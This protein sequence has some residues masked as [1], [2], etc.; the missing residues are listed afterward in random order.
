MKHEFRSVHLH[1]SSLIRLN[2][3][4]QI[5][6]EYLQEGYKL[7]VRQL[8]YQMVGR[9]LIENDQKEYRK[10]SNLVVQGRMGGLIDFEAIED[11]VRIPRLPYSCEDPADAI[12][13]TI[14]TY[15]IDR[16]R[17]QEWYTE[18]WSEKDALSGLLYDVTRKYHVNLV[19]NRGYSSCSAMYEA[20]RR[21]ANAIA[22]N[23]QRGQ[24]IYLG[25]HD[26]SGK[27][28][29]RDIEDRL[30]EFGVGRFIDVIPVALTMEQIKEYTPPPYFA[31]IK[32]PRA[33]E[34]IEQYGDVA[35]EVD[36][37]TPQVLKKV[38]EDAITER[39]D[40][41]LYRERLDQEQE[42][43]KELEFTQEKDDE[44]GDN[45]VGS[46]WGRRERYY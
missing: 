7:T 9:G 3:I 20:Y 25:D 4:N 12:A 36:A 30:N 37:L 23:N 15:R 22:S 18:V 21:F 27:D 8:F 45:N 10:I 2:T 28:M 6:E 38:L 46:T 40:W 17:G 39:M 13:D 43:I 5:I 44:E 32:D 33:K 26:P 24:I 14:A 16:Q 41:N 1:N 35:W 11:R 31:K 34:Y 29:I 42:D 19:I